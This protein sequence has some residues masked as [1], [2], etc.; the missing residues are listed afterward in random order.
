MRTHLW[1]FLL[2]LLIAVLCANAVYPPR[3]KLKLGKDLAGG[4]TILYGIK[5]DEQTGRQPTTAQITQLV[6]VLRERIDPNGIYDI[7][8]ETL[9]TNQIEISMP[10]PSPDV[11]RARQALDSFLDTMVATAIEEY[12]L[13]EVF[14]LAPGERASRIESLSA[15]VP[16][17]ES[18]FEKALSAFDRHQRLEAQYR[19]LSRESEAATQAARDAE[20]AALKAMNEALNAAEQA[21]VDGLNLSSLDLTADDED[22][23]KAI[24]ALIEAMIAAKPEADVAAARAAV[25]SYRASRAASDAARENVTRIDALWRLRLEPLERSAMQADLEFESSREEILRTSINIEEIRRV[26]ALDTK[27][28][29]QPDAAT[30]KQ[31]PG[32]SIRDEALGRVK[33]SFPILKDQVDQAVVLH[34][35]YRSRAR[36]YDDPKDLIAL[37]RGAGV[38]SFRIAARSSDPLAF[39]SL[40]E[41][42]RERGPTG[43]G[44]S[45]EVR[46]YQIDNPENWADNDRMR[47]FLREDPVGFFSARGYIIEEFDGKIYML[48]YRTPQRSLDETSGEWKLIGAGRVQDSQTGLPAVSF[49]LDVTGARLFAQLTGNNLER[50]MAIVLDDRVF[51]APKIEGRISD[52]GQITGSFTDRD[53]DYL[54]KVLNS[55]S[56]QAQLTEN[57]IAQNTIGPKL[58]LDNLRRGLEAGILAFIVVAAFML[59]YYFRCGAVADVALACNGIFILGAMAFNQAAFTMPGIAGVVL[60][61]G[62]AVD[63]NVLIYERMREELEGGADIKTAVRLGYEKAMSSIIDGN[64]TNLIVCFVL[65]FTAT[66]DVKGFAITLGIGVVSTLFSA[67]FITRAIF[68]AGIATGTIHRLSMLP[69]VWKALGRAL[70]PNIDWVAMRKFWYVFSAVAV[71][72]GLGLTRATWREMLDTEFLGGTTVTF[73]LRNDESGQPIKLP[74]AEVERRIRDHAVK[75]FAQGKM[76]ETQ[77]RALLAVNVFNLNADEVEGEGFSGSAFVIK[78]TVYEQDVVETAIVESFGDLLDI[79]RIVRFEGSD[80]SAD[81]APPVYPIVNDSLGEA[82]NRPAVRTNVRRYRGS[83]VAVVLDN[84]DPPMPTEEIRKRLDIKRRSPEFESLLGRT[85]TIVGI[86]RAAEGSPQGPPQGSPQGPPAYSEVAVVIDGAVAGV[87]YY[88]DPDRWKV[89]VADREW[90]LIRGALT[91][92]PTLDQITTISPTVAEQFRATALVSIGLSLLGIL[93]YIWV[94]FGSFRYSAAAVVALVHDVCVTLGLLSLTHYV[95]DSALGRILLIEPFKIDMGVIAA[96]LTIIGYSL[97]DTIIVMDRI[98]ENRGKLALA[99]ADVVNRSINSTISRT[100]LTSGTTLLALVIMY[101]EGGTGIRPFAFAMLCGIMVGTY[102]SIGVASPMVL[103]HRTGKKDQ[104]ALAKV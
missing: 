55:G 39:N 42:L 93:A 66:A 74:R 99:T 73:S 17:R 46:W 1:K 45:E 4:V 44:S 54:L 70:H 26:L 72:A 56:L 23:S 82:I 68:E 37:L 77:H 15:A 79:P 52:R 96:L 25:E 101:F 87:S 10:L 28:R 89:L 48:L 78:T 85:S 5:P 92:P 36:G 24:D 43:A 16:A 63:A 27:P 95:Y 57:P 75:A 53:I 98:R 88:D 32:P 71:I 60:T 34:D 50:S 41:E 9:G 90:D 80:L 103:T 100:L 64:V 33:N 21:G 83:G 84:L 58:G 14:R 40:R 3:E 30:G 18:L 35:A 13:D 102:S 7:S 61:F 47:A 8:I 69:T 20:D 97:N 29:A 51:S 38:L 19:P 59:V 94:R 81:Q 6:T 86:T 12:E 31:I 67:L 49:S 104:A 22:V 91:E 62:M 11:K 2:V 76:S 65:G